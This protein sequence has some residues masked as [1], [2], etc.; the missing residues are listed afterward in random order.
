MENEDKNINPK[1]GNQFKA[2][3]AVCYAECELLTLGN[4]IKEVEKLLRRSYYNK[5]VEN[6]YKTLT[7]ANRFLMEACG[8][9]TSLI[10]PEMEKMTNEEQR[11]IFFS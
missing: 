2:Y 1:I 4:E 8:Q 3:K 9:I 5:N 6:I 11:R 10:Q 7:N